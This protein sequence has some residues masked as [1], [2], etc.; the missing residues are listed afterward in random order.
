MLR[1]SW[2]RMALVFQ[3]HIPLLLLLFVRNACTTKWL[4]S[5]VLSS[6][7]RRLMLSSCTTFTNWTNHSQFSRLIIQRRS[8][9]TIRAASRC[10]FESGARRWCTA[11]AAI[12]T[13][14]S[15]STCIARFCLE[16]IRPACFRGFRFGFR[17]ECH[18]RLRLATKSFFTFGVL[19]TIDACTTNGVFRRRFARRFTTLA[20]EVI[21]LDC[22]RPRAAKTQA[23]FFGSTN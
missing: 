7:Q 2:N 8:L 6:T 16:H 11:L 22:D 12:S 20:A 13:Q 19:S 17:C 23:F 14:R 21:L 18:T 5:E 3:V 15:T 9:P 1:T 10:V 4:L